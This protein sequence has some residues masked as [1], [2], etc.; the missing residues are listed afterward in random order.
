MRSLSLQTLMRRDRRSIRVN[1]EPLCYRSNCVRT[2]H[3]PTIVFRERF[4]SSFNACDHASGELERRS[5]F[6]PQV[7]AQRLQA[8][9]ASAGS[10]ATL[11][12]ELN[13]RVATLTNILNV[14]SIDAGSASEILD[15]SRETLGL[16]LKNLPKFRERLRAGAT[17]SLEKLLS[18]ML[19]K[20]WSLFK[21]DVDGIV[22]VTNLLDISSK[23]P[24]KFD[25]HQAML[26]KLALLKERA[27]RNE[28]ADLLDHR[29]TDLDS[30]RFFAVGLETTEHVTKSHEQLQQLRQMFEE[31]FHIIRKSL[32]STEVFFGGIGEA[33]LKDIE[34]LFAVL[35]RI[36]GVVGEDIVIKGSQATVVG[37]L[38]TAVALNA[39]KA[40]IGM[41]Q[42]R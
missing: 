5:A 31:V 41:A 25:G 40:A 8:F 1:N 22:A 12:P 6:S 36:P 27:K 29:L 33:E 4:F 13:S 9:R 28:V 18:E 10:D 23:L 16:T 11:G 39:K 14:T 30:I 17:Q 38:K 34:K 21:E 19:G 26:D 24:S 35:L 3:A 15:L 42:E 37:H 7:V 20:M 2:R 32:T